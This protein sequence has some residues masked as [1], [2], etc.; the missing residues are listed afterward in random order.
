MR[1]L[2][3]YFF[4]FESPLSA[5]CDEKQLSHVDQYTELVMKLR[6]S[7]DYRARTCLPVS[8]DEID[9]KAVSCGRVLFS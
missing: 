5:I 2:A 9:G 3:E 1:R 6:T 7:D 4:H 8:C